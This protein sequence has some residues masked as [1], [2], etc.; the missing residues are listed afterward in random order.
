MSA[1]KL[2][3]VRIPVHILEALERG[4]HRRPRSEVI[5][6]ALEEFV[7]KQKLIEAIDAGRNSLTDEERMRWNSSEAVDSWL[8]EKRSEFEESRIR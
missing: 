5:T 6:Q 3:H 7:R 4:A 8:R 1:T 2:V